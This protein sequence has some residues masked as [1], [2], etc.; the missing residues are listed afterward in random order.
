MMLLTQKPDMPLA[1][2]TNV[3][4]TIDIINKNSLKCSVVKNVLP[5]FKRLLQVAIK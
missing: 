3:P 4:Y 5:T 1:L 2:T